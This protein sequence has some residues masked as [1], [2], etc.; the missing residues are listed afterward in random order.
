[1]S[2]L[3]TL[4]PVSVAQSVDE[5]LSAA[6]IGPGSLRPDGS[7]EFVGKSPRMT[8]CAKRRV[9]PVR[10]V[11]TSVGDLPVLTLQDPSA[12]QGVV[13]FDCRP[14]LLPVSLVLS[15]IGRLSGLPPAASAVVEGPLSEHGISFS[16]GGGGL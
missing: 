10:V 1:M 11:E 7:A 3:H 14:P 6:S 12:L 8:R 16:G 4:L 9:R 13:V 15:G 2:Q 5:V